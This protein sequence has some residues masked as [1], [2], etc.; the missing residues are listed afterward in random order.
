MYLLTLDIHHV[1]NQKKSLSKGLLPP[2]DLY[3]ISEKSI[4]KIKFDELDF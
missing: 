3:L 4:G 2:V 1:I